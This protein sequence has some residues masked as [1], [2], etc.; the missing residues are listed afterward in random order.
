MRPRWQKL[1]I[2]EATQWMV[3]GFLAELKELQIGIYFYLKYLCVID[4]LLLMLYRHTF[5]Q[6]QQ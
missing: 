6:V 4:K 5:V 1:N 3:D 2:I